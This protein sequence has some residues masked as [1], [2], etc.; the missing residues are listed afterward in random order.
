MTGVTAR[1]WNTAVATGLLRIGAG[2]CLLKWRRTLA[3]RLAGASP[4]DPVV[5]L[6]FGYFGVRDISV[7]VVTL[8]ATRPD[9]DVARAVNLQGV[10]DT[11]D[12]VIVAG[13]AARGHIPR[14]RGV[15]A[16]VDAVVTAAAEYATAWSLR[17]AR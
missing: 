3:V 6:L 2:V 1:Q 10:A 12:A 13:V 16:G 17:R 5:P 8:A 11:T 4:D 7:G 15:A 14:E 9:G